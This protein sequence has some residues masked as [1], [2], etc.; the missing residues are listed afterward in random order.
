MDYTTMIETFLDSFRSVLTPEI[1]RMLIP[2]L[3][4]VLAFKIA[5]LPVVKGWL[6]EKFVTLLF[7]LHLPKNIYR[8]Y[9]D[10]TLPTEDGTTQ[11]DHIVVSPFGIF[12][13][14]TKNMK[15][16]IFGSERQARWT[17]TIYRKKT[18][19]QNPLR[20]N[21]KHTETLRTLL[22][23][24]PDSVHSVVVFVGDSTF[25]TDMPPNVTYCRGCTNYILSFKQP[26]FDEE[27]LQRANQAIQTGRLEQ[28]HTTH[29]Q[30]VQHLKQ[31]HTAQYDVKIPSNMKNESDELPTAYQ[32]ANETPPCPKCGDKM[33]LRTAKKGPKAGQQ[34]YGCSRFPKCR[35]TVQIT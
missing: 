25:K 26:V 10:V 27:Q 20:Q 11:I 24:P 9:H 21:Y 7:R 23:L 29:R 2:L 8:V 30:H 13:V 32:T 16:W 4:L 14:E 6:G 15:G 3:L 35:G 17:Q 1:L 12:C 33:T 18:S 19:F 28:T 22:E 5:R 34:F 31:R